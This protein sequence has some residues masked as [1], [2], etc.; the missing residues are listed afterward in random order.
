MQVG[1]ENVYFMATY[2]LHHMDACVDIVTRN[3]IYKSG[4][5]VAGQRR[6]GKM[7]QQKD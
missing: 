6:R 2:L 4:R 7:Q 5:L 3:L 1:A